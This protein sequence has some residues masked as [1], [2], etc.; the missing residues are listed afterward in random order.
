MHPPPSLVDWQETFGKVLLRKLPTSTF[1]PKN[2]IEV[3]LSSYESK[4]ATALEHQ[5]PTL[6]FLVGKDQFPSL[7]A[8]P[9]IQKNPPKDWCV[10]TFTR[11]LLPW[12]IKER[13]S[14]LSPLLLPM[15]EI[16]LAFLN[17][18]YPIERAGCLNPDVQV[19]E[20]MLPLIDL[21]QAL[22]KNEKLPPFQKKKRCFVVFGDAEGRLHSREVDPFHGKLLQLM[23]EHSFDEAIGLLVQD[24]TL[25]L[26][27]LESLLPQWGA[28]WGELRWIDE[29]KLS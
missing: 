11:G 28:M 4:L 19:V 3:Y 23:T 12:L 7:I 26:D 13:L 14:R 24:S 8:I 5:L 29:K 21:R 6:P 17:A 20:S 9:Y 16:D 15:T 2:R 1:K 25:P 22:M 10:E 27:S 18:H